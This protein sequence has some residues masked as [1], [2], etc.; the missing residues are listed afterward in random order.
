M[1]SKV[2]H[3]V[4]G[5]P[6]VLPSNVTN[7][8]VAQARA[9]KGLLISIALKSIGDHNLRHLHTPHEPLSILA[10]PTAEMAPL[11]AVLHE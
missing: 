6:G 7:S 3:T 1:W 9:S 2:V 11:H 10:Q 4:I 5:T 8:N